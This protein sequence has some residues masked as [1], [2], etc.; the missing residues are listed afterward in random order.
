MNSD[1]KTLQRHYN[2]VVILQKAWY[3]FT[4]ANQSN[5]FMKIIKENGWLKRC[6]VKNEKMNKHSKSTKCYLLIIHFIMLF[7]FFNKWSVWRSNCVQCVL[8]QSLSFLYWSNEMSY[9]CARSRARL[10]LRKNKSL[11][12]RKKNIN[13]AKQQQKPHMA[14][15]CFHSPES[16]ALH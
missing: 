9:F 4:K 1:Q 14:I 8:K 2:T 5:L 3:V 15:L 6:I 7:Y 16:A 10:R 12:I 11:S 13:K